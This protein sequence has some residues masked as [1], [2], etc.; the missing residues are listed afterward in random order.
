[1]EWKWLLTV[2]PLSSGNPVSATALTAVK[3]SAYSSMAGLRNA[4]D[5]DIQSWRV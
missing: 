3:L 2:H 5:T 1:M 4:S